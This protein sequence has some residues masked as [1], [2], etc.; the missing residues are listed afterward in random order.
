M[1]DPS[2]IVSYEEVDPVTRK[3]CGE[4]A[5]YGMPTTQ[6][7]DVVL[8]TY[9]QA[10]AIVES[11]EYKEAFAKVAQDRAQRKIDLEDGWDA[12][13]ERALSAVLQTLEFNRDP[14]FSLMAA[15]V[16]N[17]AKRHKVGNEEHK[18]IDVEKV[19]ST[20]VVLN[21][22]RTYINNAKG[23]TGELN[24]VTRDITQIPEKRIDM[25]SPKVV[26]HMLRPPTEITAVPLDEYRR[27]ALE[28]AIN[29][30]GLKF[31]DDE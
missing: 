25:M 3:R 22:N 30:A 28:H 17:N 11:V 12:V 18:V 13:E 24:V 8:I 19:G 4:L 7:A 15:R 23:E 31:G 6:I 10:N 26:E 2:V 21:M 9:A 5:A 1:N 27:G 14:H 20:V 29:K 16:A